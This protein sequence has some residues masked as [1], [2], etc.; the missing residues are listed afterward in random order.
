MRNLNYDKKL[1]VKK[2]NFMII[3]FFD[4]D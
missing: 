3:L 4:L 2:D 1:I